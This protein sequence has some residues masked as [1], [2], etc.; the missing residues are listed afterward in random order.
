M[1]A[2][3]FWAIVIGVL[4]GVLARSIFL[5]SW[6]FAV[7]VALVACIAIAFALLDAVHRRGL[8][9]FS[10]A[11]A[12]LSLGIIRMD[13]AT[14]SGDPQIDPYIGKTITLVGV[15]SD[16]P[17]VRES[18]V[19]LS[20]ASE[21]LM[22]GSTSV[23]VHAG[24]LALVPPHTDVSY[25]DE[26]Q[27]KGEL[28]LPESFD[29]GAGRTFNYP[30]YLAKDGILYEL[31]FAQAEQV[32]KN[33]GNPAKIFAIWVKQNLLG[34]LEAS[35]AEPEAGLAAGITLGDKR[36]VGK[37]LTTVFTRASLVH[38][39]VLSGYNITVVINAATRSLAFLP[40]IFRFGASGLIVAFFILM[41][42][43]AATAVRA[44]L[45]A[46][47]A[48][49]ARLTGRT[50]IALRALGAAAFVMILW[51]PLT[52]AFDPSFELSALATLGLILF[53]QHVAAYLGWLTERFSL[54]EIVSSTIATQLTVLPLLLYQSGNLSIVALPA[55]I[56]VLP[57]MPLAMLLS[58]IA[59]LAGLIAP[60]IAVIAGFPA[61]LVLA[62]VVKTASL[63]SA[64]P[65]AAFT[66]PAFSGWWLA[67][68]Y[69]ALFFLHRALQSKTAEQS[70]AVVSS[71][72]R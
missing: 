12:A 14:R 10:V 66:I 72:A 34:G 47:L 37:E 22:V 48:V 7:L 6:P 29:A 9:I 44:G 70:P 16:E 15:V 26:V 11:C 51:N 17:D 24:V 23:P 52:L 54:R 27:V 45:M 58:S 62:Y 18:G 21:R 71:G 46:F 56:L 65:F 4:A 36:S 33:R 19:R 31:D 57:T 39:V 55:N 63:F 25:G 35:L 64:L 59:A 38:I 69:T 42:G 5:F 50:F 8:I 68:L 61:Y 43:G 13:L 2:P 30:L 53:T 20:V 3:V 60:P 32:G 28:Q 41:T 40:R 49:Y 67:L 1:H